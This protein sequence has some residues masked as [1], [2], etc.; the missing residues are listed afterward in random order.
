MTMEKQR[1]DAL[2]PIERKDERGE[3]KTFWVKLGAAWEN[4]KGAISILLDALPV[5]GK[6]VLMKP[7]ERDNR[8]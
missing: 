1:Y 5:N 2:C 8:R 7:K 3:A 6:I 4:D